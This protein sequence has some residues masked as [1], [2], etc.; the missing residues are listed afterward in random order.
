MFTIGHA[1]LNE[2]AYSYILNQDNCVEFH[3]DY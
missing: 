1:V 3:V 2:G